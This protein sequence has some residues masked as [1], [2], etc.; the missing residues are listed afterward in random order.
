MND[1]I[2]Q[3]SLTHD[4]V[5]DR[6][7][8]S[9]NT[10]EAK[11]FQLWLTRRFVETIWSALIKVLES[12]PVVST[13]SDRQTRQAVLEF[14]HQAAVQNVDFDTAY[15]APL[16]QQGSRPLGDTPLLVNSAQ[17]KV[18]AN[19]AIQLSFRTPQNIGLELSVDSRILH[20][21]CRLLSDTTEASGWNL[22]LQL[23]PNAMARDAPVVG[24]GRLN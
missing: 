11:E 1:R 13:Q 20:S 17:L 10:R 8:L 23:G 2:S 12:D 9:I 18:Q 16:P 21:L 22:D 6:L 24:G 4:A 15:N 14:Q 19:G 7:R 3:F 5:E